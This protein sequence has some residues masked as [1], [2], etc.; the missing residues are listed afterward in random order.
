MWHDQLLSKYLEKRGLLEPPHYFN[1]LLGNI[2]CARQISCM[3]GSMI[4]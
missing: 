2:A 3:P 1:L 4:R